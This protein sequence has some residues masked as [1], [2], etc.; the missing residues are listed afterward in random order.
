MENYVAL[1]LE[2]TGLSPKNDRI[3]E[4]GAVKIEHGKE[5]Q[6]MATLINPQIKIPERITALTGISEEMVKGMPTIGETILELVEF[7]EGFVLL[8]HN[9]LFDYSFVKQWAENT[10]LKFE[11]QGIDTLKIARMLLPDLPQKGL[12]ALRVHYGIEQEHAHRAFEDALVTHKLYQRL[13]QE[14]E[15]SNPELFEPYE[16]VYKVKKQSPATQRQKRY[17]QDLIKYHRIDSNVEIEALTKSE[18][19]R[20]IDRILSSYGK[21][22]E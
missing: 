21:I 10:G 6:R 8:G 22:M 15:T 19:S 14:Y 4:I 1:D 5:T 13:K 11:H 2:T 9:I 3:L 16:L 18:A 17:L 7:C 20:L 12:Q